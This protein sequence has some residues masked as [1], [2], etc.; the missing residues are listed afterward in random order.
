[1]GLLIVGALHQTGQ[2][3]S[4]MLILYMFM[5]AFTIVILSPLVPFLHRIAWQVPTVMLLVLVGT[6]VYNL[7]A[8]PYSSNNQLKL[9]WQQEVDLDTGI[10]TV[11]YEGLSPYVE[12]A[13][14]SLPGGEESFTNCVVRTPT[15][16]G[17]C[18]GKGLPP[19]VVDPYSNLPP[20]TQYR[21][22]LTYNVSRSGDANKARFML[23]GQNTRAC[24][25][26][27]D[28]PISGL[29]VDGAGPNDKRFPP[30]PEAGSKEIRLWSR[31]WDR[32]WTV[33]VEWEG[34]D[35]GQRTGMEGSVV[36]M[37][38]QEGV[39]PSLDEA[40]RFLPVWAAV[41]KLGDGLVEGGKRFMI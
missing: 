35:D 41:T 32:T 16:R 33:D 24:K 37:W 17:V 38:N 19:R 36:C 26:L 1:M 15:G 27:F 8:F 20:A 40:R 23:S 30:V 7:I 6:L 3:G 13:V 39:I 28:S 18:K 22:W 10:N 34:Q 4:S 2:D 12:Y 9:F 14:K 21:K 31:T 25:I 11:T 29:H 5:A